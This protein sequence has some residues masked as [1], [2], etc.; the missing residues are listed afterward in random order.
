MPATLPA[1]ELAPTFLLAGG[2]LG[3]GLQHSLASSPVGIIISECVET[4]LC[5]T[6]RWA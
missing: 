2:E 1:S 4:R 6:L 3:W 5:T